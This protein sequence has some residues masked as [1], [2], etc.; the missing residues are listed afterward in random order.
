MLIAF[1]ICI[2]VII[3]GLFLQYR[4]HQFKKASKITA[5]IIERYESQIMIMNVPFPCVE[6]N[7]SIPTAY[8][9]VYKT[10]KVDEKYINGDTIEVLYNEN[11][12]K[13]ELAQNMKEGTKNGGFLLSC[14][15][16]VMCLIL[17]SS[18]LFEGLGFLL[19]VGI[20]FVFSGLKAI[21]VDSAKAKKGE[22]TAQKVEGTLVDYVTKNNMY[23]PI[24]E[25]Y[26]NGVKLQIKSNVSGSSESYREIG[27]KVTVI[28]DS[29]NK[30][31]YIK[32]N[33]SVTKYVPYTFLLLGISLCVLAIFLILH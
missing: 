19:T 22:L 28:I 30:R 29:L 1:L 24:Y 10:M 6:I 16:A 15:G 31:V 13:I 8:G 17:G 14:I 20:L 18:Y 3:L 9:D 32:E 12:D 33:E 27:K 25:Y 5:T 4:E 23:T 2:L 11:N 21:F 26:Y 7:I